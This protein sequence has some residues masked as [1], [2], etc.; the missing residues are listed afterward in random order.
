MTHA[1][2]GLRILFRHDANSL[3]LLEREDILAH[4][5]DP[6]LFFAGDRPQGHPFLAFADGEA[7]SESKQIP[8]TSYESS[9]HASDAGISL[10]PGRFTQ[11]GLAMEA[12]PRRYEAMVSTPTDATVFFGASQ[13]ELRRLQVTQGLTNVICPVCKAGLHCGSIWELVAHLLNDHGR[14]VEQPWTEGRGESAISKRALGWINR[15]LK[16]IKSPLAVE[17]VLNEY[18]RR[19]SATAANNNNAAVRRVIKKGNEGGKKKDDSPDTVRLVPYNSPC[20]CYDNA[21]PAP[22]A[23][24]GEWT[25]E[26]IAAHT[27]QHHEKL[28]VCKWHSVYECNVQ[29]PAKM[30]YEAL[31]SHI[32]DHLQK[33]K[34]HKVPEQY[35]DSLAEVQAER[36]EAGG[37]SATDI[38]KRRYGS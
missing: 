24:Q 13:L 30:G 28:R 12:E 29:R 2:P 5:A 31:V 34:D 3:W 22:V 10:L 23:D 38:K 27:C 35:A 16:S 36:A 9:S 14:D 15:H 26:A 1:G 8:P 11:I 4:C 21:C 17:S 18:D 20:P 32:A 25:P 33:L 7:R 6:G 19:T 37:S